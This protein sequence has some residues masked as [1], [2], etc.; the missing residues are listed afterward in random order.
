MTACPPGDE[1]RKRAGLLQYR[2][3]PNVLGAVFAHRP[4][5]VALDTW[6]DLC[7]AYRE[8]VG[9]TRQDVQPPYRP[10]E[11]ILR[12]VLGT[13]AR[14]DVSNG[15][16]Q[17]LTGAEMPGEDRRDVFL[18]WGEAILPDGPGRAAVQRLADAIAEAP[19]VPYP[20]LPRPVA[21][22][23]SLDWWPG[24]LARWRLAEDLAALEWQL[25][26]A[27]PAR[28][29][30][31]TDGTLAAVGHEVP[32]SPDGEGRQ[33][34]LLPRIKIGTAAAGHSARHAVT[35]NAVTTLLAD[36]W[37]G[38]R[39]VLL[40]NPEQP[41]AVVARTDG[42]PWR[43]R[44]NVPAV[45]A[46]RRLAGLPRLTHRVPPFPEALEEDLIAATAELG[47]VRAVAPE[48]VTTPGLGR[49]HGME[50]FRRIEE[51]IDQHCEAYRDTSPVY[52]EVPGL[53]VP[54]A[55]TGARTSG[56]I[57]PQHLPAAMDAAGIDRLLLVVL[58][59]TDEVRS[60][61]Q[62]EIAR[63]WHL[64]DDFVAFD[65]EVKHDVIPGRVDVLFLHDKAG[66][67]AHGPATAEHR[68]QQLAELLAPFPTEGK[69]V[70]TLCETQWD[71]NRK[72]PTPEER[73]KAEAEDGKWPSKQAQARLG[74]SAQYIKQA[75]AP[76]PTLKKNG[77]P[78]S[79]YFIK[80]ATEA[81]ES[82]LVS[83]TENALRDLVRG[84][85]I[86][87]HR[88]GTAF[89]KL[90]LHPWWHIGIH[91]RRHAQRRQY[92]HRNTKPAP[93]T[94]TLAAIRPVD[95]PDE[96][97]TA[98]AYSPITSQWEP[99]RRTRL[100]AHA[101]DPGYDVSGFPTIGDESHQASAAAQITEAALTAA[102][103]QLPLP[104]PM[105][106][107]VD[108]DTTEYIWAGLRDENLAHPPPAG[109]PRPASWLPGHGLPPAQR[110]LAV[111][112]TINDLERIGRP[113]GAYVWGNN[114]QWRRTKTSES[115]YQLVSDDG[116]GYLPDFL[117]TTVPRPWAA[118][119]PGR[120]G[121][122]FSRFAPEAA[123]RQGKNGYA[124]TAVRLTAIPTTDDADADLIGKAGVVLINQGVSWDGRQTEPTPLRLAKQI[125][126]NHPYY[127]R[128]CEEPEDSPPPPAAMDS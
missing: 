108:G 18:Y 75:P 11:A 59:H 17:L 23:R 9:D 19:A 99:Y 128:S 31:C 3:H 29:Q 68:Q 105:V 27:H 96:P 97:W 51:H 8:R 88:L 78:C 4:G 38:V 36:R 116:T 76:V 13:W 83:S 2:T 89:G 101:A 14:W 50:M 63:Q 39:T 127:R 12:A 67:L 6:H 94:I 100:A 37:Y 91:V 65:T 95:G 61:V 115:P 1:H 125:D 123:K 120:F 80:K 85:D 110:P 43:R 104:G 93:V 74:I 58:H 41:L 79:P 15:Q 90:P 22:R 26:G 24:E 49:G 102:R 86:V 30:L 16:A 121:S 32:S 57:L 84:L 112:R 72:Y 92:G 81:R 62:R 126:T 55:K 118:G 114:E 66:A 54:T 69:V 40:S 82:G 20:D 7:R 109:L 34:R 33:R 117:L 5:P 103:T 87:D 44:L 53:S 107:Y 113:T 46:S 48:S 70:A 64:G 10:L 111:V 42:P 98:W 124:H 71:P 52:I 119:P 122:D 35:V 21:G 56:P 47:A 73:Q 60:R 25:G 45:A 77:E 28:F 106:I